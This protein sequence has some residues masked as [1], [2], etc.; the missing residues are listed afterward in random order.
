MV[1]FAFVFPISLAGANIVLGMLVFCWILEGDWKNKWKLI[2]SDKLFWIIYAIPLFLLFST[3]FSPSITNGFFMNGG[4]KNE[5]QFIVQ[6]FLWLNVIYPILITSKFDVKKLISAFLLGMFLSEIVSYSI[7]FHLFDFKYFQK[8]GLIYRNATVNNPTP[9]MHHSFYSLFL[10][11]SILLIFDNLKTFKGILK[12]ISIL[13]LISATINLFINGGRTGQLA[14]IFGA[15]IYVL[16]KYKKI[17]SLIISLLLLSII[18]M[19]A[20]KFSPVFHQRMNL[21][22]N[23]LKN[24]YYHNN[25]NSSWGKRIAADITFLKIIS[26]DSKIF[27]FGCG[28]GNAK[29]KFFEYGRK[30]APYEIK[31]INDFTHLHNQYFQLWCDGSIFA[32]LLII[33]YFIYLYKYSPIPLTAGIIAVFAFS[34][35]ADVMLYRPKTY[36]LFLFIS[37]VLIKLYSSS[38]RETSNNGRDSV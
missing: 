23:N 4:I 21:A 29:K 28:A 12:I 5:Y 27:I 36:I 10:A 6:H 20:Y 9:F 38:G 16:L 25:F 11:V 3:F 32:F 37:A 33:L 7:F 15:I 8:I 35:I 22:M 30:Y 13:F 2:K 1:L 19:L 14:L 17:K 34:F 18:F 26:S 31:F 24:V